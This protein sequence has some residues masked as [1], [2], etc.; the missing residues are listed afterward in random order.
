MIVGYAR[1]STDGQTLDAQH[2]ASREAGCAKVFAE[3]FS[4]LS[5]TGQHGKGKVGLAMAI[6]WWC[7]SSTG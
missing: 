2:A 4:T 3:K 1:V 6:R 5:L 7:V